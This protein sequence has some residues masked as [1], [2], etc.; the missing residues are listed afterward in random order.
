MSGVST[1]LYKEDIL[2]G[3]DPV[4]GDGMIPVTLDKK[5]KVKYANLNTEWYCY[6]EKKWA[7][8]VILKN[9]PSKS[10][11]TGDIISED[12]IE[13]YFVWVPRFKY[14][15]WNLATEDG[16]EDTFVNTKNDINS[17]RRLTGNSRL[18]D[19]I[20]ED[21]NTKASTT[22]KVDLYYTHPA[23][24]AFDVNGLWVAKFEA[25]G[26][27]NAITV[28]PNMTSLRSTTVGDF[29]HAFYDYKNTNGNHN[30][31]LDPHMIK[32]IEWGAAAYLSHSIYGI[33]TEVNINNNSSYLTGYSAA[34]NTE[35]SS[36]PGT[37]G[38]KEVTDDDGPALTQPY[39][40]STGYLASTTANI[41]GIYDMSG[42][43]HEYVAGYLDPY[44]DDAT[45][46]ISTT[47]LAKTQYFD[48]YSDATT[49]T[50]YSKRILGDATGELGPFY[51][52]MDKDGSSRGHNGWYSDRSDF[53]EPTNPWFCRGGVYDFGGLSGQFYFDKY[54]GTV[55]DRIGSRLVL[56]VK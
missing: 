1:T 49:L 7:N 14:K 47:D 9:N 55:Y 40:T 23:F 52:Y 44:N 48:K 24:I 4:L 38:T 2:N 51:L 15:L 37:T 36:Y 11:K 42:G 17:I 50:S 56:A 31:N 53:I 34:A 45:S 8:A 26:T 41:T 21:K 35:Q 30:S 46:E 5:G 33:G 16:I 6:E 18:I 3:A 32:N 27:T 54:T 22:E 39:N 19:V 13:S 29:W 10:Y 12:D 20:F 43:A 28:K 25:S